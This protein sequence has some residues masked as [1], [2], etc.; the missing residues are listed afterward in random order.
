MRE[1]FESSIERLLGDVATTE[2]VLGC[3]NGVWASGE[4]G[5]LNNFDEASAQFVNGVIRARF[6]SCKW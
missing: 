1:L 6:I 4:I 2:Y 3:E 5:L